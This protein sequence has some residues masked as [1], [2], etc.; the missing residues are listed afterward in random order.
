MS[1]IGYIYRI[2]LC[3]NPLHRFSLKL[4]AENIE[5]TDQIDKRE[6]GSVK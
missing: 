6:L 4:K 5:L 1:S 2:W 3:L